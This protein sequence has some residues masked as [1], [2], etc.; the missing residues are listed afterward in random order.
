MEFFGFI[1]T[2][3]IF[4]AFIGLYILYVT[5]G[6]VVP[7]SQ[8]RAYDP[9]ILHEKWT[10]V[11]LM[12]K[13][14]GPANFRQAI[15]EGDKIVDMVLRSRV[16]GQ[17]MG[18]RLKNSQRLFTRHTYDQLWTAHKIRN[19]VAH[20]ADFDGLSSDARL[21]VR[22]FEKALKELRAI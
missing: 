9:D 21:A 4:L 11:K 1:I 22:N 17:T 10:G 8:K 3:I 15:I 13:E 6:K 18:D 19:K 12:L 7:K 2:I 5:R 20:E 16:E 14:G